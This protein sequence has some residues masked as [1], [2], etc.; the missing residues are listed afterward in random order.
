MG[1]RQSKHH[2]VKQESCNDKRRAFGVGLLASCC[3]V[4]SG[5][6]LRAQFDSSLPSLDDILSTDEVP[7]PEASVP[8]LHP[9]SA[10][11]A[12]E[13][14]QVPMP[15]D[16]DERQEMSTWV[17]WLVLK[18]MPPDYVDER[19]W[20]RQKEVVT[21][22]HVRMDGMRLD[23]K[24][25]RKMVNHGTWSRFVIE[26]IDPKNALIVDITKMEFGPGKVTVQCRVETPLK[27]FGRLSQWQRDVQLYSFSVDG[28]AR[29]EMVMDAVV[30]IQVN[31]LRF[32]PDVEFLPA[33]TSSQVR[34]K[35]F[36]ID[37]VSRVGGDAAE[38]L[39]KAIRKTLEK[40]V[41]EYDQKVVEKMNK[42]IAKQ[43]DK[44]KLNLADWTSKKLSTSLVP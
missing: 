30:N 39:G 36:E 23:T 18:N 38:L 21:G 34:L 25:K 28:R 40:K 1:R 44:L 33:V 19:K 31:P 13:L 12:D 8:E 26:F 16:A 27:L 37:R 24:R 6:S 32:P 5:N 11:V 35:E 42:Q 2:R 4:L 9:V 20:N 41:A 3:W 22:L 43:K 14:F 15:I 7:I 10:Q 17:K 29:V